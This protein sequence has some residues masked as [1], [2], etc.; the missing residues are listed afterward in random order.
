M[1]S[2]KSIISNAAPCDPAKS[3]TTLYLTATQVADLLQVS[4]R[5]VERMA[6]EDTTM[7][8]LRLGRIL[9]FPWLELQLW[10][11][12]GTQ[13]QRKGGLTVAK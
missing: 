7:P 13:G 3:G 10:L 4:T 5:T 12:R 9:R 8:A 2:I 6:R 11:A 1:S